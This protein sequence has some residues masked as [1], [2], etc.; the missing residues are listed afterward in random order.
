M[1]P[2]LFPQLARAAVEEFVSN[3]TAL[4]QPNPLPP[5]MQRR[6]ASFV[7]IHL[8]DGSLRGCIGSVQ[9]LEANLAREIIRNAIAACS[10]DPR[11]IPVRPDE[12]ARLDYSVDVLSAPEPIA[13]ERELDPMRYGVIV[14][15]G[16]RRGL[17]LPALAGVDSAEAQVAIALEKA[18]I[19]PREPFTLQRFAV[20]RYH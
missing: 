16:W 2:H 6:A 3:G 7:S 10:R 14:E 9:P 8:T 17:L 19:G 12:L 1:E 5:I 20:E 4:P 11:F 18:G 15:S 13:S